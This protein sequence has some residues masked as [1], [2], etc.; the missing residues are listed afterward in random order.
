MN[1][2]KVTPRHHLLEIP[3]LPSHIP[4]Y[5]WLTYYTIFAEKK[6]RKVP[7]AHHLGVTILQLTRSSTESFANCKVFENAMVNKT[8][9]SGNKSL[10]HRCNC[11]NIII[12]YIM[13]AT[14]SGMFKIG[15]SAK[16]SIQFVVVYAFLQK[17]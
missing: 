8:E 4:L 10:L 17:W 3:Y 16:N 2:Y 5:M 15:G 1:A 7:L 12:Q 13:V 14:F 11:T 9:G 6:A